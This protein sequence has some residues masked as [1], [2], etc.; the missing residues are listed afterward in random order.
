MVS[1]ELGEE[2]ERD[3]FRLVTSL[4]PQTSLNLRPS[5]SVLQ[6][7]LSGRASEHKSDNHQITMVISQQLNLRLS[8]SLLRF[9]LSGRA[10]QCG[11]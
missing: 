6:F 8:D 5:D 1:F 10:S 11:I 4:G 3:V 7:Q 2:I 9:W